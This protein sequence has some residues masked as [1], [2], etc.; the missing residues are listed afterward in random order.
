MSPAPCFGNLGVADIVLNG[1]PI[2][3]KYLDLMPAINDCIVEVTMEG[4]STIT[5]IATDPHR[6]ILN[7]GFLTGPTGVLQ[8]LGAGGPLLTL[9]GLTF[10][11]VQLAKASDQLQMVFESRGVSVLRAKAN[12]TSTTTTSDITSWA[13]TLVAEV[14]ALK[15]VGAPVETYYP[16]ACAR[17]SAEDPNEDTWTCLQRIANTAAWRCWEY[18]GTIYFGPDTYWLGQKSTATFR[19][20]SAEISDMD[21]DWDYG[22]PFGNITATATIGLI[23]Y[24]PGQV[25]TVENMGPASGIWLVEDVQRDLFSPLATVTLTVPLNNSEIEL[26]QEENYASTSASSATAAPGT[27]VTGA[28]QSGRISLA[29]TA[30]YWIAAGGPPGTPA[31]IAAWIAAWEAGGIAP[32]SI[33]ATG[34]GGQPGAIQQGEAYDGPGSN[35]TG[36]GLWQITPG[37]SVPSAGIDY[38]LLDPLTNAK[39]A[40][41]K[42]NAAGGFAP[43]TGDPA[44]VK[45]VDEGYPVPE[46]TP[47]AVSDPGEFVPIGVA[48]PG[49]H[50][51]PVLPNPASAGDIVNPNGTIN[52]QT[53]ANG[54]P[55]VKVTV[56]PNP[57]VIGESFTV[58]CEVS[59]DGQGTTSPTGTVTFERNGKVMENGAGV[60]LTKT[61]SNPPTATL[62]EPKGLQS[63]GSNHIVCY[64][65]Q[66]THWQPNDNSQTPL[67]FTVMPN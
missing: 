65:N 23:E 40:V 24:R 22:Q 50:N 38:E 11:Y 49:T 33:P 6:T 45:Y 27:T 7:S 64:Y 55:T 41:A 10:T 18:D 60:K 48:P 1:E 56:S 35:K 9:D 4:A 5:L 54:F 29:Q 14:P 62:T 58:T 63:A 43:W 51:A 2:G 34:M 47:A 52:T 15:F 44:K 26:T 19:E 39:A 36:W 32:G 12:P 57:A 66:D 46:I 61:G 28:P 13:R 17:G 37:N 25:V 3:K 59:G 20:F 16:I 67:L 30:G 21:C 42:Y 53:P 31:S 8:N